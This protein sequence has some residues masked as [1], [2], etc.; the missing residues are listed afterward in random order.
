VA[1]PRALTAHHVVSECR[2]GRG[3]KQ[4]AVYRAEHHLYHQIHT[5]KLVA[6]IRAPGRVASAPL[7]RHFVAGLSW[8]AQYGAG[9][10]VPVPQFI[11]NT[12]RV[13]ARLDP[14]LTDT[15][16]A[17]FSLQ[18][19]EAVP[20]MAKV[21]DLPAALGGTVVGIYPIEDVPED[22]RDLTKDAAAG[23]VIVETRL[24]YSDEALAKDIR[25]RR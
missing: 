9:K 23:S 10:E 3:E 18:P 20:E 7:A 2:R 8:P 24:P 17:Y 15:D 11:R 14:R 25:N 13:R 6:D 19:E 12:P 21:W 1:L 22:L 5:L 16:G 4:D